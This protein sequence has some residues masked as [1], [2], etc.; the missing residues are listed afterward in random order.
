MKS[1]K[2]HYYKFGVIEFQKFECNLTINKILMT[3]EERS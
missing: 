3:K 2:I 1:N